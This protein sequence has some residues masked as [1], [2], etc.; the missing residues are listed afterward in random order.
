MNR[1][2]RFGIPQLFAAAVLALPATA[3][4]VRVPAFAENVTLHVI[5]HEIGHA[6]IREF[7]LPVLA[8]EEALAED[9]AT[10]HVM[11]TLPDRAPDILEARIRSFL[12]QDGDPGL[13]AEHA[14]DQQRAGRILCLAFG[15]EPDTYGGLADSLGM[16]EDA[17]DDCADSAPEIARSW[18][19]VV[20]DLYLPDSA[21][22]NEAGLR[23]DDAPIPLWL[24]DSDFAGNAWALLS[25][26][27]WHSFIRLEIAECDGT[28]QWRRNGRQILVC[29]AYIA[30]FAEQAQTLGME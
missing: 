27:D 6:L 24:S 9:F 2:A 13:F 20:D 7:D 15:L 10:L 30:R 21:R 22:V 1:V 8:S 26:F 19:R 18:R 25:A 5:A 3:D 4:E 14:T 12:V 29:D 23:F 16:D 28:A 17:R 11:A